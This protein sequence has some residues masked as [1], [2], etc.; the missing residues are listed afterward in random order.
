MKTPIFLLVVLSGIVLCM[1]NGRVGKFQNQH[2]ISTIPQGECDYLIANRNIR[3]NKGNC[4]FTNTFIISSFD[5]DWLICDQKNLIK[6]NTNLYESPT[7]IL[8]CELLEGKRTNLVHTGKKGCCN[9]I[10]ACDK[11]NNLLPREHSDR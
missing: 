7:E 1:A 6:G 4:K 8:H 2:I 9:C 5:Q 10:I 3:H 11:V